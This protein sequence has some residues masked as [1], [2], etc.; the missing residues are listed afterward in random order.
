MTQTLNQAAPTFSFTSPTRDE[1][2][3]AF[4]SWPD[5][6]PL[7]ADLV[8]TFADL[9]LR[10]ASHES[11]G[12][13][14]RFT[15]CP[16]DFAWK[17]GT[18]AMLSAALIAAAND[19]FEIDLY[20][21]LICTA[22]IDWQSVALVRA[23]CRYLR[24]AGLKLAEKNTVEILVRHPDFVRSWIGLF[25][26]RFEP[27]SGRDARVLSEIVT[28]S[29]ATT[30]TLDED[31]LLRALHSFLDATL[32]TN[33]FQVPQPQTLAFKVD[34]SLLTV[35]TAV[36]PFREVFVHGPRVEGSHVRGGL[37]ARGGLRWS[38]RKDDFRTEVLGLLKTQVVKNSLIVPN[39]AKGA[40]VVRGE[41]TPPGVRAA[42]S[43]FIGALLDVT[44]NIID[45]K[46]VPPANTR[47]YD[48]PDPYLVVAA[49][50]GTAT[51]SDLANSIATSRGFWLGD[52]FA[53]GGSV[54]YDHK[55][56]GI[57]ARG[58]WCSVRRHLAELGL[59]VDTDPFTVAGIGDMSGD[60]FGNGMLLSRQIR[61]IGAF[62][63][64]H[65]FLDPNPDPE[66]SFEERQRLATLPRSSWD[67]Y[68][69]S[70]ISDGG[71]VWSRSAKTIRLTPEVRS[72][73][74][75]T[76]QQLSP[77]ELIKALL[78]AHVDVLWNGGI[79]TY[80]KAS[81]EGH[82]V[83]ADPVNDSVRVDADEL[84]CRAVGEGGN[85]GFTQRGRVE[86]ALRGGR[87][88]ADFIDNAAGVATSDREVNIKIAL[89]AVVAAGSMT[90]VE[91]NSLLAAAADDVAAAVLA[92]SDRQTLALS[93]AEA[94]S[95]FLV[96]RHERLI[97]NLEVSAGITRDGEGLPSDAELRA[98]H[99]A[100]T[101]LVRPEIAVLLAQSKNLVRQELADSSA[102]DN[103][104]F[105]HTVT[106]YFP[107]LIRK[108]AA[109]Y[110][111]THQLAREIKS[112]VVAGEI[113][114][115]VGPGLVRRLEEQFGATTPQIA[116]AYWV[117]RDVYSIDSVW[118]S[119]DT[120]DMAPHTRMTLLT[121]V[122]ELIE[123]ATAWL[124][125]HAPN[126][127]ARD[128][129]TQY[130]PH[131][132]ALKAELP[133][134]RG[135]LDP[136]LA[137]LRLLAHGFALSDTARATGRPIG[138]VAQTYTEVGRAVG[139]DWLAQDVAQNTPAEADHWD[140]LAN[141]ILVAELNHQW[142]QLV[143]RLLLTSSDL[144]APAHDLV[145]RWIA[146]TP[147]TGRVSTLIGELK[148]SGHV[149]PARL[150]VVT[151]A[152]KAFGACA[153]FH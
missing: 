60:V 45:Q 24:Q 151:A 48:G 113:I 85:L 28:A 126:M 128:L 43:D 52:A 81:A 64:R 22:H 122:Q 16:P 8:A 97:E 137:T 115:R 65:I 63:H 148:A 92:D 91:R 70:A 89:D 98:R 130:K 58:A 39:G 35:K 10:V 100:G 5:S 120:L 138:A 12:G 127:P 29:I 51:F 78:T 73:L 42:Y 33:W 119:L 14:H 74:G 111:H 21:R 13:G 146:Q 131:I 36:T 114:N 57:T 55:A 59:D 53:S 18:A 6:A 99:V 94:H 2:P 25:H 61:L 40:F 96:S 69:R 116:V 110:L 17:E 112:V 44:D 107:P 54:G 75:V 72:R 30:S 83:A 147:Q 31:R 37:I 38:D 3:V 9:G 26:A 106:D 109:G 68:R 84:A 79:G 118:Q 32:R 101:G 67:D 143:R 152:F 132:E 95:R 105:T 108:A 104:I 125:Q 7:L 93:L 139:L 82:S 15:F 23:A 62:D 123:T 129:I 153:A 141:T 136:D 103:P 90:T 46:V 71:G 41:T 124:L 102:L 150:C 121:S 87:I 144:E 34:P 11:V 134:L 86:Y 19:E 140:A 76:A 27:E 149:T 1:A 49:D 4:L 135:L 50:K 47:T 66:A 80:V 77:D 142:H 145:T 117:V 20:A 56:M 88:N 133:Q